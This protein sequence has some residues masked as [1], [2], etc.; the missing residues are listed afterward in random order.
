MSDVEHLKA[1]VS[2]DGDELIIQKAPEGH[3]RIEVTHSVLSDD[4]LGTNNWKNFPID[5]TITS[6]K[7]KLHRIV[8]TDP[9]YMN[10]QL[11]E[12]NKTTVL[13]DNDG[14]QD[15]SLTL[16]HIPHLLEGVNL[17]IHII[18][19][20]PNNYVAS[21][22]DID[23]QPSTKMTDEEYDKR[24]GTYRKWKQEQEQKQPSTTTQPSS[25]TD[26]NSIEPSWLKIGDKCQ[27]KSD[28]RT[29]TIAYIGLVNDTVGYWVGLHLDLPLGKNDGTLKGK[30]YFD[31]IDKYGAFVRA[32]NLNVN[33]QQPNEI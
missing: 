13:V 9:K 2:R 11:R 31:S 1:F 17:N 22:Q 7:E 3:V 30:K 23:S 15:G 27:V 12:N 19:V 18:D 25:T 21:L 14:F 28:L 5:T 33:S 10:L 26:D 29:G 20:D 4:I 6:L 8:G 16:N 32:S 24:E